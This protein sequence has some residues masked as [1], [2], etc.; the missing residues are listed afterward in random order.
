MIAKQFN[1]QKDNSKNMKKMIHDIRSPLSC[2]MMCCN[3]S[4]ALTNADKEALLNFTEQ[5]L[6]ILDSANNIG[7]ISVHDTN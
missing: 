7:K 2:L 3:F 6:K 1:M 4:A 5:I